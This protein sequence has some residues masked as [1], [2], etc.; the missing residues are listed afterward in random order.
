MM[1]PSSATSAARSGANSSAPGG[2]APYSGLFQSAGAAT[3]TATSVIPPTPISLANQITVRLNSENY[4]Y[5]RTQIVPIL[6]SNLLFGFVDGSLPCPPT[7]I[8]NPAASLNIGA[9][10]TLPNPLFSAWC[11]QDQAI[12]SAIVCSLHE[13]VLGLMTMV[14]TSHEA[15]ETLACSFASQST[16][17]AMAIRGELHKAKKL[18]NTATVFFNE[19][20][21]KADLLASIGQPL[22]PDEFTGYL[23]AGLDEQYDALVQ[24][25]SA[26]A[27]TDPMPVRDVYAQL[28]HAEQRIE[29][30]RAELGT[31]V[32][33]ANVNYR[34]RG[35][36][37][38]GSAAMR[39]A[40]DAVGSA[41]RRAG[42]VRRDGGA[43]GAG[44]GGGGGAAVGVTG[45]CRCGCGTTDAAGV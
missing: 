6:R 39:K 28:M 3:P 43:S 29:A 37:F 9:S 12:L 36:G 13:H 30:R 21:S 45:L 38:P 19:I 16:A 2:S 18:N 35:G 31:D 27:L 15:W 40:A 41:S 42:S 20:Q 44:G 8:P 10:P 25:V 26:R 1:S 4:I 34:T 32:H 17:R 5:W 24:M 11:Q 33:M 22:R 7:T 14:T 23:C